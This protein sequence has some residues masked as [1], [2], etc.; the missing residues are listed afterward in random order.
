MRDGEVLDAVF[1]DGSGDRQ[2]VDL[3]GLAGPALPP[4]SAHLLRRDTHDLLACDKQR[5][6][7]AP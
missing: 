7:K 6:F 4:G 5:L 2:R 3:I 1:D